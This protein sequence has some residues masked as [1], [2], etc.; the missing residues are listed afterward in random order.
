[1]RLFF[2]DKDVPGCGPTELRFPNQPLRSLH[3][4]DGDQFF[5]QVRQGAHF[6]P[7]EKS[8][9]R[10]GPANTPTRA[11]AR[12]KKKSR[13][14]ARAARHGFGGRP[15]RSLRV[16]RSCSSPSCNSPDNAVQREEKRRLGRMK[17]RTRLW[18]WQRFKKI[19][20]A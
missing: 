5:V 20:Q 7:P 12:R 3:I 19:I 2:D 6:A 13:G 4:D 1:M 9:G 10:G 15:P 14:F 11:L 16:P 17:R 18:R 8:V